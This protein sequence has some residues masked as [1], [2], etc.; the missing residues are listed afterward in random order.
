MLRTLFMVAVVA[1]LAKISICR[2]TIVGPSYIQSDSTYSVSIL[3]ENDLPMSVSLEIQNDKGFSTSESITVQPQSS[4]T[5]NFNLGSLD[6]GQYK[7]IATGPNFVNETEAVLTFQT[8][9]ISVFI[10]TDKA[11]YKPGDKVK[12][13]IIVVDKDLNPASIK[14]MDIYITDG[15]Q[16]RIEQW[17]GAS[18]SMGVY[19]GELQLGTTPCLGI[20]KI[21][22]DVDNESSAKEFEVAEYVLPKFEVTVTAPKDATY[23]DG[24][25]RITAKAIYTYGQPVKGV[26]QVTVSRNN[27]WDPTPQPAIAQKQVDI[28]GT[29]TAEFQI[30]ADLKLS[31][32]NW[33]DDLKVTV[34]VTEALTGVVLEGS[35]TATIRKNKFT[36][37][38]LNNDNSYEPG[39]YTLSLQFSY[40]DGSPYLDDINTIQVSYSNNWDKT[41]LVDLG[42]GKIGANGVANIEI[43][44]PDI[45]NGFYIFI[46][47]LDYF[48]NVGYYQ[49]AQPSQPTTDDRSLTV[50]LLSKDI[51]I[52]DTIS[53]EVSSA[54]TLSSVYYLLS[55]RGNLVLS[56]KVQ[57]ASQTSVVI[58]FQASF[59]MVPTAQLVVYYISSAGDLIAGRTEITVNGLNNF[60]TIETSDSERQPGESVGITIST[61]P[62]SFVCLLGVDQSVTL[63]KSGNDIQKSDARNELGKYNT[64][65]YDNGPIFGGGPIFEGP[66]LMGEPVAVEAIDIAPP[67][68]AREKR[69]IWW[70]GGG[71][72]SRHNFGA[73]GLVII[74]T[75]C[76]PDPPIYYPWFA[77]MP[78]A[79]MAGGA[80]PAPELAMA[81][82]TPSPSPAVRKYFPETWI[83]ECSD[84]GSGSITRNEKAPDTITSWYLTGFATNNQYGLGITENKTVFKVFKNFFI[85]LNLPY[86][87]KRGEAVLLQI[88]IFNYLPQKVTTKVTLDNSLQQFE[89][90]DPERQ[91][92][93]DK[94]CPLPI[95]KSRTK[96]ITVN[97]N[98]GVSLSFLVTPLIIG[99]LLVKVTATSDAAG[100][101]IEYPLLVVA[102]GATQYKNKATFVDLRSSN[103]FTTDLTVDVPKNVVPDST[104]VEVSAIGDVM[105]TA[106]QNIDSLIR[107]PTGCG[108]Q[109]MLGLAPD[110]VIYHYLYK[111]G[112]LTP[113]LKEKLLNYM[114]QGIQNELSYA[115]SDH[116]FS[117]FG[118]SDKSGSSWLTAFVIRIFIQAKQ[119][120]AVDD[121]V[122]KNALT[123]LAG[124]Q[125]PDG[126]F[127]EPGNVCHTDMQGE[128]AKGVAL[129]AYII[130]TFV[131]DQTYAAQ[132]ADVIEKGL[133]Y[134]YA[135]V[136][137]IDDVYSLSIVAY[138]T[139]LANYKHKDV[140]LQKLDSLAKVQGDHRW[141]EK[142]QLATPT[143]PWNSPPS[144]NVEISGYALLAYIAANRTLDGLPIV[145]WIIS[146]QSS[147][148]GFKST[149]DTVVGVTSLATF[150][151]KIS[152]SNAV[153]CT[154]TYHT[155]SSTINIDQTNSLV[156]QSVALP[157]TTTLVQVSCTGSGFSLVQ[158]SYQFNLNDAETSPRFTVAVD[159][160]KK[161]NDY[162]L[163][164][165]ICT[166]FIAGPDGDTTNMAIV[167][168]ELP[169]GFTA[170]LETTKLGLASVKGFKNVE[171]KKGN[172][173]VVV[174]LD[175]LSTTELCLQV[176]AYRL[177]QV[178]G[179]KPSAVTVQDYYRPDRQ[180]TT[181]YSLAPK[182]VCSLCDTDE[183]KASCS[184]PKEIK[185]PRKPIKE[186]CKGSQK[187]FVALQEWLR[188]IIAKYC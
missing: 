182:T 127:N 1:C 62:S 129:T 96:K 26:A 67:E 113:A 136:Q 70:P 152:G 86:S 139:Q 168:A 128:A 173:L 142:V 20:W 155:K 94:G 14:N 79:A 23:S 138:A 118:N 97:S 123:W 48:E 137:T 144:V 45:E 11:M 172:T 188:K 74:A 159:V 110:V 64:V 73:A 68:A 183:C 72:G 131:T 28:D 102:E 135:T 154:F 162:S 95:E 44:L 22:V 147:T 41:G 8:K 2:Y 54:N 85:S 84:S 31:P 39:P 145:R 179:Q 169:T 165:N 109:T 16:N 181:F 93:R 10:Q 158:L 150:A 104:Q 160:D 36:V 58:T 52:G 156:L 134:V 42:T 83:W 49:K 21:N 7:I 24:T 75:D 143:D 174:Y 130:V 124:Q 178:A 115:H 12:F 92:Y 117:A 186:I 148:G 116:S 81:S 18:I 17:L 180:K 111:T 126:R 176:V 6:A 171:T 56:Q 50:K 61:K 66:V 5:V 60:V 112:L 38:N 99:D 140:L 47:F 29:A 121:N 107:M 32:D 34:S 175:N 120:T 151:D 13:R 101:A 146:Q 90:V 53:V 103:K 157:S 43:N 33:Q 166:K 114:N 122:I 69:S 3:S 19:V 63:L 177:C 106:L 164:L 77:D 65:S 55:A 185:C 76:N 25:L 46:K 170:D 88:V 37:N 82:G 71:G 80:A 4:A 161:S 59:D 119:F 35:T 149:Q 163:I 91:A 89:F 141:W 27:I 57:V 100:D 51:E 153:S 108:E 78:M 15:N 40:F 30:V 133:D 167:Q 9:T 184:K 105:G 187:V 132:Y 98:D 125:Q 87:V